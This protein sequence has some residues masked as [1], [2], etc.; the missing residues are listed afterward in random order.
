MKLKFEQH[1]FLKCSEIFNGYKYRNILRVMIENF[2]LN[3]LLQNELLRNINPLFCAFKKVFQII[4][5]TGV[6]YYPKCKTC[7]KFIAE[8]TNKNFKE[9]RMNGILDDSALSFSLAFG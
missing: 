6:F 7:H 2:N 1:L 8:F 5:F 4:N 3:E 9:I